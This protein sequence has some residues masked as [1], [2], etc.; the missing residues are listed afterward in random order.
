MNHSNCEHC[1][2]T[3]CVSD[4]HELVGNQ[5]TIIESCSECHGITTTKYTVEVTFKQTVYD[6]PV[7]N[8]VGF[9]PSEEILA[10]LRPGISDDHKEHF[11]DAH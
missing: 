8:I 2:K 11:E 6:E 4:I 9:I 5:L 3:K 10:S 1:R 7:K